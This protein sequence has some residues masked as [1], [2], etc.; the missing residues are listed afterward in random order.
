MTQSGQDP[1]LMTDDE[2]RTQSLESLDKDIQFEKERENAYKE[3]S[4]AVEQQKSI[5]TPEVDS[6]DDGPWDLG[7]VAKETASAIGGGLQDTASSIVTAPERLYDMVTGEYS[8]E[9][10]ATGKYRPEFDPFT[11]HDNPIVTKTWAGGLL[12][13]L[14]HYGT[15]ALPLAKI[16]KA[17]TGATALVEGTKGFWAGHA[18]RSMATGAGVDALSRHSQD[19]N[20]LGVVRDKLG[21]MDTPISTNQWDHPLMKTFKNVVEGMGI[22]LV[23]DGV[24]LAVGKGAK[25]I[26]EYSAKRLESIKTQAHEKALTELTDPNLRGHKNKGIVDSHQGAP[27]SGSSIDEARTDLRRIRTE[28]DAEEGSTSS[29]L[30]PV[31]MERWGLKEALEFGRKVKSS[32][33]YQA[34][35]AAI[36]ANQST[37]ADA[38][39]DTMEQVHRIT[40]GRNAIDMSTEEYWKEHIA[41]SMD[42]PVLNNK[43]EVIDTI[44]TWFP[45][46]IGSADLVIG[47]LLRQIRDLGISGR[48]IQDVVDLNAVDGSA[49]AIYDKVSTALYEVK[50]TRMV[51]SDQFRK[52]GVGKKAGQVSKDLE[53]AL[54]EEMV[55]TRESLKS[56]MKLA[57]DADSDD[58]T[59]ALWEVFSSIKDV[60]NLDD[61]DAWVRKSIKGGEIDGKR[62]TGALI[63]NLQGVFAHSILSGPKTPLRAMM[64]TSTATFLR[65]L[66]MAIGAGMRGDGVDARA[67]LASLNAMMQAIPES[68]TLFKTRLNSYWNGDIATIKS[69]FYETTKGDDQWE[70]VGNY[71]ENNPDVAAHDKIMYRMAN[72]ARAWNNSNFLTYSTKLMAATDDAFAFILGRAEMRRRSYLDAMEN[73]NKG[74]FTDITPEMLRQG[75][76]KFYSEI[77]DAD[78]NIKDAAVDFARKEVTLT[79]D[80]TGFS[81]GL[82]SVFSS[83][84]LAKPFFMFARTGV[85]GLALTAKHTPGFNF[86]VKEWNEIRFADI[87][88]DLSHLNKYGIST[89]RD[90]INARDLQAGRLAMGTS[91]IGLASWSY[92]SGNL[93]GNGPTDR[94]KRQVWLDAGWKPRSI[95][96]G[97]AWVSYESMEPFNQIF[98]IIGDVGDHQQLMGDEWVEDNL[99]KLGLVVAQ[100]VAS[101]SYL[102]GMQ[103]FV[104]LFAGRPGQLERIG[105]NLANNTV[106]L[107][108]L[109]NELGKLFTPYTRELGSGID[110]SIRN[111]NLLSEHLA[112]GNQLPIKYDILNGKPI[113]DHNFF[114]RA[115]NAV[116]PIQFNLDYSPGRQLLFDSGYDLRTSTYYSPNGNDLSDDPL[117]RSMFQ[118][119]IGKQNIEA[120]LNKLASNP[121]VISSL[122]Q[123]RR[124]INSNNRGNF[125]SGDYF[126]NIRIKHIINRARTRAW[127]QIMR[128]P[129]VQ[130]LVN[131]EKSVDYSRHLKGVQTTQPILNMYK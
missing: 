63:Q 62:Q 3:Y 89:P 39:I 46:T 90:L 12:R 34:E 108:G 29:V 43:G 68:F 41:A 96:V 71:I 119:A 35:V 22:G 13:G 66:S 86:M 10:Y 53:V 106:P 97:D 123:M 55:K 18:I 27:I 114:V 54:E 73:F 79:Q 59:K 9:L 118:E 15:M 69:R 105:A 14:V 84:P 121:K 17:T 131:R 50:R 48:E 7:D 100:G 5:P 92:M 38:W 47:T 102:A 91:L 52:I 26:K 1:N 40:Q 74:E 45:Q 82:N 93:S 36:K 58:L 33:R 122:D 125:E 2:W 129:E 6:R 104:D 120:Q 56:M 16:G 23:F 65:P 98:A 111:R 28:I 37:M 126:H 103:Q 49:K 107:S 110:Q 113:K 32:S 51:M 87:N 11:D 24:A 81:K 94:Q 112:G 25:G 101:K 57:A 64:G 75:E 77:F 30:T 78:G 61:F 19:D 116:S 31:E 4:K 117:I 127:A 60:N 99:L 95:K 128:K 8:D 21:W 70:L 130:R 67:G 88:G 44:T 85:N 109:R 42:W 83:F 115:F 72:Q 76:D 20:L 80:L 124:D